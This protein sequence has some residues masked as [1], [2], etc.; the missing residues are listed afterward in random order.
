MQKNRPEQVQIVE[1]GPRDGLQN[2]SAPISAADRIKFIDLLVQ[3]GLQTIEAGAFV[4][5]K[6]VPQMADTDIILQKLL[7]NYPDLPFPVLV[8]NARGMQDALNCGAREIAVFTAA[9]ERFTQK[10]INASI[11]E[12]FARFA[13]VMDIAKHHNIKVRGYVSCITACPYDGRTAPQKVLEITTKLLDMGCYEVS[14]GDTI[15]VATPADIEHLLAILTPV[16][17]ADC[18]ALHCHD[19]YGQALANI[20]TALDFGLTRF[21]AAAAGLGGCPYAKGAS[22]NV[23][24]E[25][26]IYMLHGLGIETG[27]QLDKLLLAS[28]FITER[29]NI[30]T[31]A[32]VGLARLNN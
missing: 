14:L 10:N 8:P 15:G 13:P 31:R 22:G 5:P 30:K 32:H 18:L 1:V 20:L 3:S 16:T 29:L 25:D 26:L 6:W 28:A 4:S 24:T 27:V 7:S 11:A 19:T 23:A 9:S 21:D 12:S 2:E 17:G